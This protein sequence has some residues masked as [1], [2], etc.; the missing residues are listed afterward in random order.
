MFLVDKE[1]VHKAKI[2]LGNKNFEYIMQYLN[3]TDYDAKNMTASVYDNLQLSAYSYDW[4][5]K[6][7]IA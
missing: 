4:Q 1:L 6:T 2:I 5:G 7:L 3:I